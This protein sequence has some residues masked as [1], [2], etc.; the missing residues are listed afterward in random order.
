[1]STR[2]TAAD[3]T[4]CACE[5]DHVAAITTIYAHHVLHGLAGRAVDVKQ[6]G[7][8]LGVRY[9]R[10]S[11]VRKGGNR[12]RI[13]AQLIDATNG[14]HLWADRFD[15]LLEEVFELQDKVAISVAG[16]IEPTLRQT[17]I[18]RARRKKPDETELY[19]GLVRATRITAYLK[20]RKGSGDGKPCVDT[21]L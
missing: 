4:I 15:G 14:T 3:V 13:T 7:R 17:E 8:E 20:T 21:T 11:P 12:V 19:L 9:V 18:E 2:L 6:V 1:M 10:E 16:V 5:E